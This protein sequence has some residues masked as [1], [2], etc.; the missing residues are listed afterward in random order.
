MSVRRLES[1]LHLRMP[2]L[3]ANWLSGIAGVAAVACMAVIGTGLAP[4]TAHA[5]V[6]TAVSAEPATT[7][8]PATFRRL[9]EAQY[10]QSIQD[11][12]GAGIKIP[13]RFEPPL[14]D[15]GLLAIGDG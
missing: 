6:D 12:F 15:E 3:R 1:Q 4:P 11:I 14:R 10:K 13:G 2:R 7:G 8:G 9:S 5:A